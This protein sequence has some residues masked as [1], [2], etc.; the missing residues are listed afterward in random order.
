MTSPI[1]VFDHLPTLGNRLLQMQE[2]ISLQNL[3]SGTYKNYSHQIICISR[4]FNNLPECLSSAEISQ[5]LS[6]LAND[7]AS[8][9][10]FK[11]AVYGLRFYLRAIGKEEMRF[12][13][14]ALK[15]VARLPTVLSRDECKRLF[16][17]T[18][19][20]KH[21][22]ALLLI[23]SAGLRVQETSLMKLAD[24]DV[25]RKMIYVKNGK[26]RKP[27]YVP[28]SLRLLD[29][30]VPYMEK[31]RPRVYLFNG[32]VSGTPL[33]KTALSLAMR[34][35]I[36]RAHIKKEG[37]CLH[38]LRHSFATHLLEDG[39][40]IISI[41][42]LLGHSRIE[43]TMVYLHVA[44]YDKGKKHSPLDN[45]YGRKTVVRKNVAINAG[46]LSEYIS[47]YSIAPDNQLILFE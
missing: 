12:N 44:D 7:S 32:K 8:P 11:H 27:R 15:N 46:K 23:Y 31:Y 2:S 41:K 19:N 21:K 39:L 28:L 34:N 29:T 25:Q 17:N 30:L 20:L 33:G 37:A 22:A 18:H 43:N 9:S 35:A 6:E 38:T 26:G 5:Y 10:R 3:S 36:K 47:K 13:L 1:N 16:D 4:H 14:P 40:D 45:L 42:E 24:V